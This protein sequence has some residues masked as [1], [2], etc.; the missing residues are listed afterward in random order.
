MS[1]H[2]WSARTVGFSVFFFNDTAT[3]EIYTL[4]LHDALPIFRS[5]AGA[6]RSWARRRSARRRAGLQDRFSSRRSDGFIVIFYVEPLHAVAQLAEGDSQQLR[7]GGAVEL[8]LGE[9]LVDR[10]ALDAV[11]VL[12]ERPAWF[13]KPRPALGGARRKPQILDA[14]LLG[15][16]QGER[17]LEDVLELADIAGK[18]VARELVERRGRQPRRGHCALG[19]EALEDARREHTHVLA[20]F[21][22]R[23]HR[24]LD[25]V[26]TVEQVLPEAARRDQRGELLM[27]GADDAHPPLLDRA[28]QLHLH[29]ERQVGHLVEEQRAPVRRLEE[30]L[31]VFG[32]AG[33]RAFLVAEE[34][35]V[36]QGF[37]D[38]AAIDRH[39][40][41]VAARAVL[42][43]E[44]R[45]EL[46]AAARL[47]GD[48]H[49]RLGARELGDHGA[50]LR[51]R[52][53]FA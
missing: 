35:A 4:S 38:G 50:H 2:F 27:R 49:R 23:R 25:D 19:G 16:G 43:D 8:G 46:L 6:R 20:A 22:Q 33:E 26:D 21:A 39:E 41:L 9:R 1:C 30:A 53:A 3:T 31:A 24:Q 34:L 36:H 7:G 37:R 44:A 45:V 12:G 11:Q 17:A 14:D 28:Q 29:G 15:S 18:V 13:A 52:R 48:V 5:P 42:M 51:E 47:P 32:G 10:P 40:R